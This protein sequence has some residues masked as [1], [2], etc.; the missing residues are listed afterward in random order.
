MGR[1]RY[2][3][4]RAFGVMIGYRPK[5]IPGVACEAHAQAEEVDCTL[6]VDSSVGEP[7]KRGLIACAHRDVGAGGV[8]VVVDLFYE[9][10]RFEECLGGPKGAVE[11]G[12]ATLEFGGHSA[13]EDHNAVAVDDI[14][15]HILHGISVEASG[16][17]A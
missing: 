14:C 9:L 2:E 6:A 4:C 1:C 16:S 10:G 8:V 5:T 13:I 7:F 17:A 11:I 12:A 3:R 15:D